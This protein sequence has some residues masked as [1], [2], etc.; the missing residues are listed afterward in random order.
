[1]IGAL[2]GFLEIGA[3]DGFRGLDMVETTTTGVLDGENVIGAREGATV[4]GAAFSTPR[5]YFGSCGNSG[6]GVSLTCSSRIFPG[7][8]ITVI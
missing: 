5:G 3:F 8:S 1:M 4:G 2:V 7:V 6:N